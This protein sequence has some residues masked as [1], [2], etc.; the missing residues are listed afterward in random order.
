MCGGGSGGGVGVVC[1]IYFE[2]LRGFKVGV[3]GKEVA[4]K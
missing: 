3:F 4:R 2:F 1:F